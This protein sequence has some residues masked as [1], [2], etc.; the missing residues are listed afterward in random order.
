LRAAVIGSGLA[1]VSV[2]HALSKRGVDVTILD[3]GETLDARRA[4]IVDKLHNLPTHLWAENDFAI[5]KENSTIKG[6]LLPKKVFFGSDRI[7]A[8]DRP[9]APL[10]ALVS[11]RVPYPTFTKGGFSNIWGAAMLPTAPCDMADWPV[12]P[13]E[14]E[15]HYR[16]IA[17]L[18]P[19]CGGAGTLSQAFPAYREPLGDID[20]SPQGGALLEDLGRVGARLART[21][22]LF[23]KARLAIHTAP[24]EDGVL[25]CN[26]CGQCFVGC[27]RGSIFSTLPL[28]EQLKRRGVAYRQG[29]VVEAVGESTG[30]ATVQ[31]FDLAT[32]QRVKLPFDAV[33]LAAGPLNST[34]ILLRSRGLFDQTVSLKESQKF[35][36]PL[37]RW[38][39]A[40]TAA[41]H[42]SVTMASVF[43]ELKV[44]E[45][46]DH[47][48]HAQ[49]IPMNDLVLQGAPLPGKNS[50]IGRRLW[51][52]ALRRM[53]V[54]WCGMHSD[55][56]SRVELTLRRGT[57]DG[58]DTL[59]LNLHETA[60][61]QAAARRA[62]WAFFRSGLAY[63]TVF[64]PPLIRIANPGSG[65]HCGA[66]F[67]MRQTPKDA[68]DSDTLGRPFNWKR[69]HAVDASVLPS[70]PGTTLAFTIMAN[71][72][73]IGTL[74]PG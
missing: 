25:P 66:A 15:P 1:G 51:T 44:P 68:M 5:L 28:L 16:E 24:G 60:E 18:V 27:V 46:S 59:V 61:A 10:T 43:L 35:V 69:V 29:L 65:T 9:F 14:L 7:Y 3:V 47:W 30:G 20:P 26:G 45:M 31:G 52:P 50:P 40:P 48:I 36:L 38:R 72:H 17:R 23:G 67:P 22:T 12:T 55:H 57:G 58:P 8:D 70:I 21:G 6:G 39:G 62:A 63:N 54:A 73:R 4:A 19:L 2:A 53:M 34:R 41:E 56:S 33:F 32:S 42:P 11:G 37:L 49:V 74:A 71:A 64:I 13:A